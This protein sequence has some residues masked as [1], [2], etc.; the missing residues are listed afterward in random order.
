[1]FNPKTGLTWT[2]T[3]PDNHECWANFVEEFQL[4]DVLNDSPA[5]LEDKTIYFLPN[6]EGTE[7]AGK[8]GGKNFGVLS[9]IP[10]LVK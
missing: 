1:M 4:K 5:F 10:V 3:S 8:P 7:V 6:C 9:K 2:C